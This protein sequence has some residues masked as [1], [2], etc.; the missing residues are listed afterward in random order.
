[1]SF[2]VSLGEG[3]FSELGFEFLFYIA[4]RLLWLLLVLFPVLLL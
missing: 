3:K 1:M 4:V 2:H